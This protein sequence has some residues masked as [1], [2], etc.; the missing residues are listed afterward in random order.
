MIDI[1]EIAILCQS[2]EHCER[3]FKGYCEWYC[4]NGFGDCK[5]CKKL[6]TEYLEKNFGD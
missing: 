3:Y 5:L 6:Y 1:N 4:G 2:K